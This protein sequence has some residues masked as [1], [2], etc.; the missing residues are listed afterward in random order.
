MRA[1]GVKRAI[2]ITEIRNWRHRDNLGAKESILF[3]QESSIKIGRYGNE[4]N[5]RNARAIQELRTNYY[6]RLWQIVG[7]PSGNRWSIGCGIVI[8]LIRKALGV[9][10]KRKR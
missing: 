1:S 6:H 2:A 7:R 9:R 5:N 3:S 10:R 4:D 8:L